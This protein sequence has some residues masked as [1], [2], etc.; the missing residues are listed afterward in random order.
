VL[1]KCKRDEA[2]MRSLTDSDRSLENDQLAVL[3]ETRRRLV[4]HTPEQRVVLLFVRERCG[5]LRSRSQGRLQS[6]ACDVPSGLRGAEQNLL[7]VGQSHFTRLPRGLN[8]SQSTVSARAEKQN[9]AAD[10]EIIIICET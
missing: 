6:P 4:E 10:N 7:D 9:S 3:V 2:S 5:F 8:Q 1:H